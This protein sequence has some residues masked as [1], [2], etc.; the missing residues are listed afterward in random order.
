[1]TALTP[2]QISSLSN[3]A[4]AQQQR[5]VMV[6][7][8]AASQASAAALGAALG[9]DR[10]RSIPGAWNLSAWDFMMINGFPTPGKCEISDLKRAFGWDKKK[11]KGTQGV[12]V[13]YTGKDFCEFKATF[14]LWTPLHFAVWGSL[15]EILKYRPDKGIK[16]S[17]L[18]VVHP[19]LAPLDVSA[20][21]I[22][23]IGALEHQ[24][25]GL[26]KVEIS[27]LEWAPPPPVPVASPAKPP[28]DVDLPNTPGPRAEKGAQIAR[29]LGQ[30]GKAAQP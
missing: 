4:I 29:L 18:S 10:A 26:F 28:T 12:S 8:V 23:H 21:V 27:F 13:S 9:A 2:D 20:V 14:W 7:G 15:V 17:A 24:G 3:P 16:P 30:I 1:M 11:G 22:Q 25:E 6:S 19:A 5:A